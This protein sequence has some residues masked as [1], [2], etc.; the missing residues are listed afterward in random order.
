LQAELAEDA[1]H[2]LDHALHL[3]MRVA[4]DDLVDADPHTRDRIT[5]AGDVVRNWQAGGGRSRGSGPAEEAQVSARSRCAGDH[6]DR[7][8]AR[9]Q[10]H[11]AARLTRPQVGLME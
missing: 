4:D 1:K 8:E 3:W 6:A 7:I 11:G 2:V 9:R 5:E 10:R